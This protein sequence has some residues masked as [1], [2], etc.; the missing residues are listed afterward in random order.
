MK[1]SVPIRIFLALI[2]V[3][4]LPFYALLYY[5]YINSSEQLRE[6]IVAEQKKQLQAVNIMVEQDIDVLHR[7]SAFLAGL[8]L[9]DDVITG[10]VDHRIDNLLALKQ[11]VYKLHTELRVDGPGKTVA[12]TEGFSA[13]TGE[14]LRFRHD[15]TASFDPA[16]HIG[17]VE[18]FLPF[19]SLNHYF[20]TRQDRWCALFQGDRVAGECRFGGQ[21]VF[22]EPALSNGVQIIM[23][24]DRE[25]FEQPLILLKRQLVT[26]A[27]FSLGALT[28]LFIFVSRIVSRP[29]AQNIRL[30]QQKLE[31]IEAARHA[32]EAK[33][34]FISQMSHEFR[35]PLNSIIGFSQFLESEQLLE[36]EY[37]KI[38]AMIEH[39]GKD[40]LALV[41]QI[42]DFAKAE[43]AT[44]EMTPERIALN[45]LAVEVM[46]SLRPQAEAKGLIMTQACEA[47]SVTAD[48]RMLKNILINLAANA[49]KY[50]HEGYV[51]IDVQ[52]N[53]GVRISVS[54]SGIGIA[55]EQE[56]SLFQPFS[57]LEGSE[58]IQG[59]GLGL[60]L[61]LAYAERMGA[62][63]Y[64]AR[65]DEGSEFVLQFDKE[66]V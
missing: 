66:A 37:R 23:S 46:E 27:L 15:I 30:Q 38:P 34:R 63:L 4:L 48:R 43:Q 22:A 41:D 6:N 57:R 9:M 8:P 7:E 59:S 29:I 60:A 10:D 58:K 32:A 65:H 3:G 11:K 19:S 52:D 16:W 61:C 53:K 55:P 56:A 2:F 64:Y 33:S 36:E 5:T 47:L 21:A 12:Q 24:I 31:L 14:G 54:D 35:S 40:L 51:H 39:S 44:L 17:S 28:L 18:I 50:T 13:D 25:K 45:E 1:L 20:K 42:L 49:I 26:L 62:R